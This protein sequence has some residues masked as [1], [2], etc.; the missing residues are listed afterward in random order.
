MSGRCWRLIP[1]KVLRLGHGV[2]MLG[3]EVEMRLL[4]LPEML[5][6]GAG[7]VELV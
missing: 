1:A 5:L 3:V 7:L 4:F 2:G 6:V